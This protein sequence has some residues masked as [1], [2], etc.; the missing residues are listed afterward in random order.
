M[1][2]PQYFIFL[3]YPVRPIP[4]FGWSK[5]PHS[6]L[7][8]II[9]RNRLVYEEYLEKFLQ[10]K[11]DFVHIG[12]DEDKAFP[13]LPFWKNGWLPGLDSVAIYGFLCE[14]NPVRYYEIGS[15]NSTKYA[16]QAIKDHNLQ[17]KI[18]SIDPNPRAEID[19]ICDHVVRQ[20]LE[21]VDLHMFDD[22]E[23]GDVLFIDNSHRS[24]MNSDV[25]V[26]FLEILPRL[27]PGV[28]VEF[29][30]IYLP[31][32]YPQEW[33]TRYYNEQYLL[34]SALLSEG[35]KY[36]IVFPSMFIAQDSELSKIMNPLWEDPKM[37]GVEKH[38]GSFWI[39]TK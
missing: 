33:A 32:D 23:A 14:N 37:Q 2:Q 21:D 29:H 7:Y 18:L 9:N 1:S 6:K 39:R 11:I 22:L 25:T 26:V 27:K 8:E 4:R 31:Y 15:G 36:E 20:P 12:K 19:C 28:F 10:Y 30:D 17:T 13:E 34:A 38:G 35:T 5:P 24:F 16:K 3:D